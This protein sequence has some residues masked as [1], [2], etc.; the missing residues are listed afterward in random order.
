ME[1]KEE[2]LGQKI[3]GIIFETK[4]IYDMNY[5]TAYKLLYHSYWL[6]SKLISIMGRDIPLYIYS[7][8]I[9]FTFVCMLN[10]ICI[11]INQLE[12]HI[13]TDTFM[14]SSDL[15]YLEDQGNLKIYNNNIF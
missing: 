3:I 11:T 12:Q 5:I 6:H 2:L 14:Y 9:H 15:S 1:E 13:Y 10:T 7:L 8:F 4:Y